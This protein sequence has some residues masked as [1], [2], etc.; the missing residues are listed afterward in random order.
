VFAQLFEPSATD[1]HRRTS[2]GEAVAMSPGEVLELWGRETSLDA[3]GFRGDGAVKYTD[4]ITAVVGAG[5]DVPS[6]V[7]PLA[8]AI[9]QIAAANV[10]RAVLPHGV[11]PIY[12]RRPDVELARERQAGG[13]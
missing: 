8:R 5:A 12:V 13:A 6:M 3:V 9:A 11:E 2:A 7:P 10:E 4:I 1:D